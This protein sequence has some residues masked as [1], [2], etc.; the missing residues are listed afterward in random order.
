MDQDSTTSL[1]ER[2]PH[3][4]NRPAFRSVAGRHTSPVQL[5]Q[6]FDDGKPQT[7]AAGVPQARGFGTIKSVENLAQGFLGNTRTAVG[8]SQGSTFVSN[9]HLEPYGPTR[10]RVAQGIYQKDC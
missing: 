9:K 7:T 4:E 10:R 6:G 3:L 8:N 2:Q 5:H 1:I